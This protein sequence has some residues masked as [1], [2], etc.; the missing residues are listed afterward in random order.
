MK[1]NLLILVIFFFSCS[2]R[3]T[4]ESNKI[5]NKDILENENVSNNPV[6]G[7]IIKNLTSYFNTYE[8]A[9]NDFPNKMNWEDAKNACTEL[10]DGWRL[11]TEIELR[12]LNN[13]LFGFK[14]EDTVSSKSINFECNCAY[15]SSTSEPNSELQIDKNYAYAST[16]CQKYDRFFNGSG[17]YNKNDLNC[18]RAIRDKHY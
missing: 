7:K 14:N 2:E 3:I 6:I 17:Y 12:V 18:V 11:P 10:G 8:F 5:R 4:N 13:E 16:I 15:W 9:Q 1:F